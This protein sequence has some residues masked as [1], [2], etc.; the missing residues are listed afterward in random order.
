MCGVSRVG[1]IIGLRRVGLSPCVRGYREALARD[2]GVLGPIPVYTGLT[3][4][5]DVA[6][7]TS[8]VYPRVY[9]ATFGQL[10]LIHE[11]LGLSP[12]MRGYPHDDD[13]VAGRNGST[14]THPGLPFRFRPPR[15]CTR[16]YPRVYGATKNV[17]GDNVGMLGLSPC[18]RGHP[19]KNGHALHFAGSIPVR[20]RSPR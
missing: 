1:W 9:G 18:V 7:H 12:R 14:P 10:R 2:L 16:V 17:T 15:C 11:N 3:A 4:Y 13:A 5:T 8:G 20:T 19:V 6:P